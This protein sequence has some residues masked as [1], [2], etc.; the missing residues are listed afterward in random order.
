MPKSK[1]V[2]RTAHPDE[3]PRLR[4]A[5]AAWNDPF[6]LPR[7]T[8]ELR[9]AASRGVFFVIEEDGVLAA[10][11]GVFDLRED[12]YVESGGTYVAAQLRG[13]GLQ[14]LFFELRAVSVAMNFGPDVRFTTAIAPDNTRSSSNALDNGFIEMI[15][16]PEQVGDPCNSCPKKPRLVAPRICCCDFYE[17]PLDAVRGAAKRLLDRVVDGKTI[18]QSRSGATKELVVRCRLVTDPESRLA[19]AELAAGATW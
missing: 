17:M 10:A 15:P 14:D 13:F 19:L 9:G 12:A 18:L 8:D 11:T 2:L 7:S 3:A 5:Y 1:L 4:D 6:V 16:I